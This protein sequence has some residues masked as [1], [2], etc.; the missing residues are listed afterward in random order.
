VRA[1][2]KFI[3]D[4]MNYQLRVG[5]DAW[6]VPEGFTLEQFHRAKSEMTNVYQPSTDGRRTIFQLRDKQS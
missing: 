4:Q 1:V 3:Y 5:F 2:G 6:D